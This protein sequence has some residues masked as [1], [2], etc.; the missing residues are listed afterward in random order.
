MATEFA[1]DLAGGSSPKAAVLLIVG[2][3]FSDGDKQLILEEIVKGFKGWDSEATGVDINNELAQIANRA[4]LGEEGPNGE[5]I[6]RHRSEYS[7]VEL[8][9]NPQAQT[10]KE[11][12]KAILTQLSATKLVIYAGYAFQGTAAW[13]VQDDLFSFATFNQVFKD[14]NVENALK[15]IEG[16][17]LMLYTT[18]PGDW[19]SALKGSD[20]ER[21]LKVLVNPKPHLEH[22][23]GVVQFT[24]YVGNLVRAIP[25]GSMLQAS[26]V[27]G[28]I[29][30]TR[31]VLYIFPGH[32]GDAALFGMKGFNMLVNGGYSRHS[33]FWDF[34]RH[35]D[36]I[37]A[38]LLTHLGPDNL[39]GIKAL[40]ERKAIDT[41][42]PDIDY[43]YMNTGKVANGTKAIEEG[44][45]NPDLVINLATEGSRLLE[46]SRKLGHSPHPLTRAPSGNLEPINLFHK[47][48][49][50]SLDM[51]VLNPV[52]DAKE[53]K[54]FLSQWDKQVSSFSQAN[55]IPIPNCTSVCAL[56]VVRPASPT[57]NVTRI[58]FPGTAPQYKLLEGLERVKHLDF[59]KHPTF[60]TQDKAKKPPPATAGGRTGPGN[61]KPPSAASSRSTASAKPEPLSAAASRSPKPAPPRHLETKAA[62][63]KLSA[64][65]SKT[66]KLQKENNNKRASSAKDKEKVKL[67]EK[68]KEDKSKSSTSSS[69][70]KASV[71]TTSPVKTPSSPSK[72]P[73][74]ASPSTAP[75]VAAAPPPPS[76]PLAPEPVPQ[77]QPS[78]LSP[79]ANHIDQD[80]SP[81]TDLMQQAPAKPDLMMGGDNRLVDAPEESPQP[82]AFESSA[83]AAPQEAATPA[84]TEQQ[85]LKELGIYD[86]DDD[87]GVDDGFDDRE[88]EAGFGTQPQSLPEPPAAVET[89][90]SAEPDLIQDALCQPSAME[91]SQLFE[92]E[93]EPDYSADVKDAPASADLAESVSPEPEPDNL[94]EQSPAV[95]DDVKEDSPMPEEQHY[96]K[97]PSPD[98]ENE[99]QQYD[100]EPS[101]DQ[102]KDMSPALEEPSFADDPVETQGSNNIAQNIQYGMTN[103]NGFQMGGIREEEEEEEEEAADRQNLERDSQ[104][105]MGQPDMTKQSMEEMGIYDDDDDDNEGQD[106]EAAEA[107]YPEDYGKDNYAY[108]NDGNLEDEEIC[109]AAGSGDQHAEDQTQAFGDQDHQ[110]SNIPEAFERDESPTPMEKQME[111]EAERGPEVDSGQE[112][113]DSIDGGTPDHDKDIDEA[114]AMQQQQKPDPLE[115]LMAGQDT[116][117]GDGEQLNPFIGLG[118]QNAG[119]AADADQLKDSEVNPFEQDEL[120]DMQQRG[121][122]AEFDPLAQWGPPTGLPAPSPLQD[123]FSTEQ[124]AGQVQEAMDDAH[125]ESLLQDE[126]V[127][128]QEGE[129]HRGEDHMRGQEFAAL[130]D[131]EQVVMAGGDTETAHSDKGSEVDASEFDPLAEWGQPMG[132]P[133][134]PPPEASSKASAKGGAG[135]TKKAEPKKQG[136]SP[137]KG[138][139]GTA[140]RRPTSGAAKSPTKPANGTAEPPKSARSKPDPKKA[141]LDASR[142]ARPASGKSLDTSR[143]ESKPRVSSAP[144]AR[145]PASASKARAS[146]DVIKMPPL[147]P[148]TPFYMDLTYIPNHGDISYVDAEFFKR[149][150]ARYYVLSA[151]NP[152]PKVLEMLIDAKATWD[153]A[154]DHEV[155]V[156]PTYE[157]Q[158]LQHWMAV[159]KEKLAE[160][161]IEIAPAASRCTVRLQDHEDSCYTYRLEF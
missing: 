154:N 67:D 22:V 121:G 101:P 112:D 97:E 107:G 68:E 129:D 94:K 89:A 74:A 115:D 29:S 78:P 85:R 8:L 142:S 95:S 144:T 134:P 47:V 50:G 15:Q 46:L 51:Y 145:K 114:L 57:E 25:L 52:G 56:L 43:M 82:E 4:D 116:S 152:N 119:M 53:M 33:C 49:K 39:F 41:I 45:N 117:A 30:F 62:A 40:L 58:L 27:I 96:D 128:G 150:R 91:Q 34:V 13:V 124:D 155:T 11:S 111:P 120:N 136:A 60:C 146:P 160:S 59:L 130:G 93:I 122:P 73:V 44:G 131:G 113:T 135:D 24:A 158:I 35:L 161:K 141:S 139:P 38:L 147:P 109:M 108:E 64:A 132:L 140:E 151:R 1:D 118:A 105:L 19:T 69:P 104:G 63:S 126:A 133:S 77:E 110:S 86:D 3:P 72:T 143:V 138:R 84:L 157:T 76:Q 102:E 23:H 80:L 5:R 20:V 48:G 14:A 7:A 153:K 75:E 26:D 98:Q 66:A 37:D 21:L 79:Q 28:N 148:F 31:P 103:D 83:D 10:V 127:L 71:K 6:I 12:L 36:G 88:N 100:K 16:A 81:A 149:I 156:I 90:P 125:E 9:I 2:E 54:D 99:E 159:H 123:E 18:S 106:E 87:E 61:R 70:S 55:G 137:M 17:T 42:H 32:H 92:E 65:P